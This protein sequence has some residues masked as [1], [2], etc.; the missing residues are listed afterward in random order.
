[1]YLENSILEKNELRQGDIIGNIHL[2][3]VLNIDS[4]LYQTNKDGAP[5]GWQ[6]PA[7]QKFGPVAI[8]S[9]SCEI[10]LENKLKITSIILAPIRD[11][12][13]A[14]EKSKVKQLIETNKIVLG[15]PASFLK[16]FYLEPTDK[17][18][19]QE[20]SVVDFSKCFSV[21]NDNYETILKNKIIQLNS[22]TTNDFSLK[23]ALYYHRNNMPI[24]TPA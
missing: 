3:G 21:K 24:A 18:P 4:I 6:I 10:S 22:E 19:F 11:V 16:Y 15:T 2:L 20:G 1:M 13:S 9:H 17:L 12:N 23:M 8:L 5:T 7:Q 14:S